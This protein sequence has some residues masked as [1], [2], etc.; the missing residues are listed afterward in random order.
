MLRFPERIQGDTLMAETVPAP[1]PSRR[2]WTTA[3]TE[4]AS[5]T[6]ALKWGAVTGVAYY[7]VAIAMTGIEVA[8]VRANPAAA[9]SPALA[10]PAFIALFALFFALYSAGYVA[11]RDRLHV[12]PGF[13]SAII[14]ITLS[15]LLSL[16]YTPTLPSTTNPPAS[17]LGIQIF[18]FVS[19]LAIFLLIGY[20]GAFYGVKNKLKQLAKTVA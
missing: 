14:M 6:S 3:L 2:S 17:P 10:I 18:S 9:Q 5:L 19:A 7:L 15:K 12:A 4:S 8:I 20:M 16:L 13:V 11:G 1:S